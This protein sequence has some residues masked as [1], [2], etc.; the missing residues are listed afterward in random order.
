MFLKIRKTK[1]FM[2]VLVWKSAYRQKKTFI[3]DDTLSVQLMNPKFEYSSL[4]PD[5]NESVVS[6]Q[7]MKSSNMDAMTPY[8]LLHN[9]CNQLIVNHNNAPTIRFQNSVRHVD[10][11]FNTLQEMEACLQIIQMCQ[12]HITFTA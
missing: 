8:D 5:E 3:L 4:F 2:G 6:V 11:Q 7:S 10:I 12:P 9:F 1:Q